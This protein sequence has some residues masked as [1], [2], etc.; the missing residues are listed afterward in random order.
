MNREVSDAELVD[1]R[2]RGA[3]YFVRGAGFWYTRMLDDGRVI[4]LAPAFDWATRT[5]DP[6]HTRLGIARNGD[7]RA[8]YAHW[9]YPIRDEASA[10]LA[11]RA[12]I[13]WDGFDLP[14]EGWVDHHHEGMR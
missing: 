1:A 9:D 4:Y 7:V 12:A 6:G 2:N 3:E 11:W 10:D 5:L 8:Y 14:L 13:G